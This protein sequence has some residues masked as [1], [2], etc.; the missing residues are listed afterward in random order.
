MCVRKHERRKR[1]DEISGLGESS[2]PLS[3]LARWNLGRTRNNR[4]W[5]CLTEGLGTESFIGTKLLLTA[6]P[7]CTGL[8]LA[9]VRACKSDD[10]GKWLVQY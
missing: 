7:V 1:R 6:K 8:N 3:I 5:S 4:E 9:V 2:H 10:G